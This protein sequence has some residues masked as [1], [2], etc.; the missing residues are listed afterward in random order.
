A[1][2]AMQQAN[3][4]EAATGFLNDLLLWA[5]PQ[6]HRGEER[7]VAEA[8]AHGVEQL[9]RSVDDAPELR[10]SL[11]YM[12]GH[13][14]SQRRDREKSRELYSQAYDLLHGLPDPD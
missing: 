4:A 8:V 2:L 3:R 7:T 1:T 5:T 13:V 10:A 6:R 14:Y 11:F 9:Q 12:L